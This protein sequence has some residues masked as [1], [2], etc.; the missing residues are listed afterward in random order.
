MAGLLSA[1]RLAGHPAVLLVL[2]AAI[3][4]LS[5]AVLSLAALAMAVSHAIAAALDRDGYTE[6]G[7]ISYDGTAVLL[8]LVATKTLLLGGLL[9]WLERRHPGGLRL[10]HPLA[11]LACVVSAGFWLAAWTWA[12]SVASAW[13]HAVCEDGDGDGVEANTCAVLSRNARKKG[14]ALGTCAG[15]GALVWIL[16][17]I[18]LVIFFRA[19]VRESKAPSQTELDQL[20]GHDKEPPVAFVPA[21][22]YQPSYQSYQHPSQPIQQPPAYS[23]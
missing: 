5:L 22:P 15:L 10:A 1:D 16:C 4:V 18:H 20:P 9:T 2:R 21:P 13:L 12:A 7:Y 11:V 19:C 6:T 8:V 23:R 14:A 3:A 17:I